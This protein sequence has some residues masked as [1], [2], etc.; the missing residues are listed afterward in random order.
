M[1]TQT[2][3]YYIQQTLKGKTNAYGFLVDRYKDLVFGLIYRLLQHKEETEE[4]SQ[5]V[6]VKAFHALSSFKGEASFKTWLYRIA[7]NTAISRL[8]K[9]NIKLT[10]INEDIMEAVEPVVDD[11]LK[12]LA[13]R[14]K[15]ATLEN[16]LSKLAATDRAILLLYYWEEMNINEVA[17]SMGLTNSN[18]KI[19][20][21]RARKKL[22]A[23]L[24]RTLKSEWHEMR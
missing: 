16:G 4:A 24:E 14:E 21:M 3:N 5:D 2:D 18:V 23:I 15:K 19:K 10:S 6:F 20:L 1:Q 22:Y 8:R 11:A 12:L 9:K 13:E 7:Y 17:E